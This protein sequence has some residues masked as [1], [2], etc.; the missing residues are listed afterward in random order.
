LDAIVSCN[1]FQ[2]PPRSGLFCD[3]LW[4][5]PADEERT[6][7]D[8]QQ[9]FYP[10]DVR[11]CSYFFTFA[12]AKQF[13]D[14][15]DLLSIIR[16]H[17][18]QLDGYK[19]HKADKVTHFPTVIT[20]FSAPNYC[21]CY[22]NKGA[23]LKFDRNTLNIQQFNFSAHPYYLPNFMDVFAWSIP[24]VSEKVTE[25][26]YAILNPTLDCETDT[27]DEDDDPLPVEIQRVLM[28]NQEPTQTNNGQG[29]SLSKQRAEALRNKVV[30]V[31]RLCRVLR[32]LREQHELI[33][34]LKG[35]TPGHRIPPGALLE[36]RQGLQDEL[37]KF[38]S[39]KQ[40]DAI[41]ERRPQTRKLPPLLTH[42]PP[43][44]ANPPPSA[45]L[46]FRIAT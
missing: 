44:N 15:N 43:P 7:D 5:D 31:G 27:D 9:T 6:G 3:L 42:D 41:N 23:I 21:D 1:R 17:E 32:T 37:Q 30:A 2:E 14:K 36:G 16:A 10:N 26:L 20:I 19:M 40:I 4:A 29:S 13:L 33:V 28:D 8:Q 22:N 35:V 38:M 25:M 39:V 34:Q 24:F 18:A 46:L 45:K 12:A 11:G